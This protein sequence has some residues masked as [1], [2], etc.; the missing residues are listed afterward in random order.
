MVKPFSNNGL[1]G[2]GWARDPPPSSMVRAKLMSDIKLFR[3]ASGAV[4]ELAG[5]TDTVEKSVQ[6][7]FWQQPRG[8]AGRS[9]PRATEYTTTRGG[10]IDMLRLDEYGRPV[11]LEYI[12]DVKLGHFGAGDPEIT[13]SNAGGL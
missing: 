4:A 12:R 5:T 1:S 11:I 3:M 6:V 13:S 7:L 9:L 10:R 8:A 2:Q